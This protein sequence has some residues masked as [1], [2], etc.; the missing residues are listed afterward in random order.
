MT[1]TIIYNIKINFFRLIKSKGQMLK[2]S[3]NAYIVN[4]GI[5][6]FIV[7]TAVLLNKNCI[8]HYY[9]EK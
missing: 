1:L 7:V 6:I 9:F 2:I 5:I 8:G 3:L 4:I